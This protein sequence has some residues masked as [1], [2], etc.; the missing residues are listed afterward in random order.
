MLSIVVRDEFHFVTAQ[1]QCAAQ[2]VAGGGGGDVAHSGET[3]QTVEFS[4]ASGFT[5]SN[6]TSAGSN[7]IGICHAGGFIGA[8][9]STAATWDG[10]AMV[11]SQLGANGDAI[12]LHKVAPPLGAS[13]VIVSGLSGGTGIG[14]AST[15][16]NADQS[17][18]SGPISNSGTAT[19]TSA[20][21]ASVT[22]TTAAGEMVVDAI[23]TGGSASL[24]LT[25]G[26]NQNQV[27]NKTTTPYG[28]GSYQLGADGGVMSW[29]WTG[30][31]S[32]YWESVAASIKK[33]A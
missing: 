22:V 12:L 30:G 24:P 17:A 2:P 33:A 3:N 1:P 28:G 5:I 18:G 10:A 16:I 4:G 20:T 19:A 13:S 9:G 11:V 14:G 23:G 15:Y 25:V 21:P 7:R 26:A 32:R 6:Q 27:M 29:S 31:G 8:S